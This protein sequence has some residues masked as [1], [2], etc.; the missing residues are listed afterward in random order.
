MPKSKKMSH[1]HST[2]KPPT[3][4]QTQQNLV[5]QACDSTKILKKI[6]HSFDRNVIDNLAYASFVL[7]EAKKATDE[8]FTIDQNKLFT[9]LMNYRAGDCI[10]HI[11]AT[12]EYIGNVT[13]SVNVQ[14]LTAVNAFNFCYYFDPNNN[15]NSNNFTG[16]Y[17][18]NSEVWEGTNTQPN[19]HIALLKEDTNRIC[20]IDTFSPNLVV[21]NLDLN[22]DM[23]PLEVGNH[24]YYHVKNK[25]FYKAQDNSML[26]TYKKAD[27]HNDL[28]ANQQYKD[29]F[30]TESKQFISTLDFEKV[31]MKRAGN[32]IDVE[33][34]YQTRK[35]WVLDN[36]TL[37][38][39][40]IKENK[41]NDEKVITKFLWE[42]FTKSRELPN[43]D[44]E[45]Y[46]SQFQ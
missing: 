8:N 34:A 15:S 37:L 7:A 46:F 4:Q 17:F 36:I 40:L 16:W 32:N 6:T 41:T 25:I 13:K 18:L 1:K 39:Y 19:K 2:L 21:L 44:K 27:P 38:R 35:N 23:A 29:Q 45:D 24:V 9:F 33:D 42:S 22:G 10:I 14:N 20:I 28:R 43:F 12:V 5:T 26:V 3:P 11:L 31:R 30:V